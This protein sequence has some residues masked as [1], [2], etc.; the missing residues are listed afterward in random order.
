[1]AEALFSSELARA[2][3]SKSSLLMI[4]SRSWVRRSRA[5]VSEVTSLVRDQDVPRQ[6]LLHDVAVL[7]RTSS[8]RRMWKPALEAIGPSTSPCPCAR[9][10]SGN[11]GGMPLIAE[12][13]QAAS[14]R[15]LWSSEAAVPG[16]KPALAQLFDD[17][18]G[19][20]APGT[21]GASSRRGNHDVAEADRLPAVRR[22]CVRDS[23]RSRIWSP[24]AV[25]HRGYAADGP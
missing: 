6:G 9:H 4:R 23:C 19:L 13:A 17:P 25:G 3:V 5:P 2:R 24:D 18:G 10:R 8:S 1:M 12:P 21:I 7:Q 11:S 22:R 15:P 16:A 14:C 20:L